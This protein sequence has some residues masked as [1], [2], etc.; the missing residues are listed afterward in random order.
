MSCF[1]ILKLV[2]NSTNFTPEIIATLRDL[3]AKGL[4]KA[5]PDL[6]FEGY[7]E[8]KTEDFIIQKPCQLEVSCPHTGENYV[9]GPKILEM[10]RSKLPKMS[11]KK[12]FLIQG[13]A[14]KPCPKDYDML[15]GASI[16]KENKI[17]ITG[18][19][20]M[21]NSV[22]DRTTKSYIDSNEA[23]EEGILICVTIPSLMDT[24]VKHFEKPFFTDG[25]HRILP[26]YQDRVISLVAQNLP[27]RLALFQYIT[28]QGKSNNGEIGFKTGGNRS[29]DEGLKT[30]IQ[31]AVCPE[32]GSYSRV[33]LSKTGLWNS[34]FDHLSEMLN[35]KI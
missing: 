31:L 30:M 22:M 21:D 5:N 35:V 12:A 26:K 6:K 18:G 9:G 8:D 14:S 25:E 23:Q 34:Y 27:Q 2:I 10:L 16:A 20:G 13:S 19:T 3:H 15:T 17:L 29:A 33:H 7:H 32:L 24:S 28:T 11:D 4:S 1:V